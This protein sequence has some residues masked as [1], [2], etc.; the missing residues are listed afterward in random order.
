[1]KTAFGVAAV[2]ATAVVSL[3]P[4]PLADPAAPTGRQAM[5]LASAPDP[6]EAGSTFPSGPDGVV[7]IIYLHRVEAPP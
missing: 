5:A 6:H 1:M 2:I 4:R 3:S 7:P